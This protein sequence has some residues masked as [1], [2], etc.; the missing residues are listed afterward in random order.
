[1]ESKEQKI[2]N[3]LLKTKDSNPSAWLPEAVDL[4]PVKGCALDL[5]CGA[6]RDTKFLLEQGFHVI[7]VDKNEKA[8][9][10]LQKFPQENLEA[11]LSTFEDFNFPKEKFDLINAAFSLPFTNRDIF[12]EIFKRMVTSLKLDGVFVGQLFG[13]NDDWNKSQTTK[14]TFHTLEEAKKIFADSGMELLKIVEKDYDGTIADGTPKHWHLFHIMARKS[15][16]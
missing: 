7:A 15:D 4:T 3:Y 14:T 16:M 9:E 1:M 6:G 10:Y 13:V 5:G 11:I 8:L 2:A 12:N